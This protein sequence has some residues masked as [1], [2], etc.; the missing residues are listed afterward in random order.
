MSSVDS[1][2]GEFSAI[3]MVMFVDFNATEGR[4]VW[5]PALASTKRLV[6]NVNLGVDSELFKLV[7]EYLE[8]GIR[9]VAVILGVVCCER[10]VGRDG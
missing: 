5:V 3:D 6:R 9:G 7:D 10:G 2:Y 1:T 8:L 4:G